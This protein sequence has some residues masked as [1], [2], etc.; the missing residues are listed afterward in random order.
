MALNGY[1]FYTTVL[2][3]A[4]LWQTNA[5][6]N[7]I[8]KKHTEIEFVSRTEQTAFQ[9]RTGEMTV[10]CKHKNPDGTYTLEDRGKRSRFV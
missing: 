2:A 4:E 6:T 1:R 5:L 9:L 3:A 10:G 7:T 8:P